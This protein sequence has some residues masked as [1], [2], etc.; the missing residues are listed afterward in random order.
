MNLFTVRHG[1]TNYNLDRLCNDDPAIDVHLTNKGKEQ[2]TTVSEKLKNTEFDSIII[3]ELPRTRET[4]EL[5]NKGRNIKLIVDP[6]IND[7]KTGFEGKKVIEFIETIKDDLFNKKVNNGESFQEEKKRVFK[8]LDE[9]KESKKDNI[10]LVSHHEIIKIIIG[11]FNKLS[12]QEI[13][14]LRI[15]NCGINQFNF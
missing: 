14:N 11:Y 7:R 9:L 15:D 10:L 8:F 2:A 3:S 4:A 6:R 13:W 5:I 1:Q 12:D